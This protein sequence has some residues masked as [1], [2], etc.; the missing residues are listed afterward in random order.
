[1]ATKNGVRDWAGFDHTLEYAQAH[2]ERVMVALGNEWTDCEGAGAALK[3]ES[4]YQSGYRERPAGL[5]TSY[6]DWVTEVVSRYRDRG[7]ILAWQLINEPSAPTAEGACKPTARATFHAFVADM[8]TLVKKIDQAHLVS[9]GTLGWEDCAIG[10]ADYKTVNSIPEID[11]CEFH[12]YSPASP[13]WP[14]K[15]MDLLKLR[16]AQCRALNKPLVIAEAGITVKDA[17]S[18]KARA[19]IFRSRFTGWFQA[20]VAGVLIWDWLDAGA[21]PGDSWQVGAGDP[22]LGVLGGV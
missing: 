8:A 19:Q 1:M 18:L 2:G 3:T 5:L 6:R 13:A 20:G 14:P 9:L 15:L 16:L 10:G 4:W 11:L 7:T 22:V 12:D 21:P 17:G